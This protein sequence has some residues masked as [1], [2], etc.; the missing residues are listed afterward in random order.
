MT[1][2][3]GF[4]GYLRRNKQ[5][6]VG[7]LLL[8]FLFLFATVGRLFVDPEEAYPLGGPIA[9]PP[10]LE[11]P[12]GTDTQGRNLIA[13]AIVGTYL[14]AKVGII[15][16]AIGLL[17]GTVVGFV[18][19]YYGGVLDRSTKLVVD[20]LLAIPGLLILVVVASALKTGLT[21]EGMALIVAA[22]AW[23]WPAR[24]IRS[25]V[26]T[27]RERPFVRVAKLSGMNDLEII[28]KELLPNLLPFL[29]AALVVA[30]T[31]AVLASLG[32]EVLGLGPMREP[33]MGVTLYWLLYYGA[34]IRGMWWWLATPVSIMV[35]LFVGL[36]LVSSGLDELANPRL[37]RRV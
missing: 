27:L 22:L 12:L 13:V 33:T 32:L 10:S 6:A 20:T 35:L 18:S 9:K 14:T 37:R 28:F 24:S 5:L 30:V 8:L 21:L 4:F 25:Q 36:F 15:A 31:A 23:M 11:Y 16:G 2:I 7:I 1:R 3:S 34:L 17:I 26:L 29:G 19:G